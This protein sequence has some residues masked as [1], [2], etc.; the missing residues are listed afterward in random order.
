MLGITRTSR[1]LGAQALGERRQ[2]DP[3]R[4]RDDQV[5]GRHDRPQLV[6]DA[7]HALRLDRQDQHVARL[8]DPRRSAVG[9][10]P[11]LG[12]EGRPGRLDG[13][14]AA[15]V[16]GSAVPARIIPRIRAVAILPA[17]MKPQRI[18]RAPLPSS[19]GLA[20]A[21]GR[22]APSVQTRA[23]PGRGQAVGRFMMDFPIVA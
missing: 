8:G 16:P 19:S 5:L 20:R 11:G 22:T 12:R 4:D 3:G 7:R 2:R 21:I 15:I 6:Q 17:P 10:D 13:S 9:R 1:R 14:L 23:N 18:G